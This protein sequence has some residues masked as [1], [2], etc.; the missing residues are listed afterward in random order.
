M[1]QAKLIYGQ[2]AKLTWK[3]VVGLAGVGAEPIMPDKP[4][5]PDEAISEYRDGRQNKTRPYLTPYGKRFG[6]LASDVALIG[7]SIAT[8]LPQ[9]VCP[10]FDIVLYREGKCVLVIV[11]SDDVYNT[12]RATPRERA[13]KI[14][15]SIAARSIGA[16]ADRFAG[17]DVKYVAVFVTYG[18]RDFAEEGATSEPETMAVISPITTALAFKNGEKSDN[19]LLKKSS[20]LLSETGARGF[21]RVELILH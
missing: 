13:A 4:L 8:F 18:A 16:A 12:L 6:R 20:I 1:D 5:M 15:S 17:S 21:S 3:A 7:H 19:E 11:G 2:G 10:F 14:F 9:T